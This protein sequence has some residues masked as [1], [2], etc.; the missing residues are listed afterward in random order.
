MD[1]TCF[2]ESTLTNRVV[3][4]RKCHNVAT[5]C[6]R[7][8]SAKRALSFHR[9]P[10]HQQSPSPI[11]RERERERERKREVSHRRQCST[12]ARVGCSFDR[13]EE[14][15]RVYAR[16]PLYST[17]LDSRECTR[18]LSRL[19]KTA[20]ALESIDILSLVYKNWFVAFDSLR[21]TKCQ[22]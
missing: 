18:R 6:T 21:T 16:T 11:H 9:A 19:S 4:Y 15:S 8:P 12:I 3:T 5:A 13:H 1:T 20:T 17:S 7:R 2:R 22:P 14:Y 10:K